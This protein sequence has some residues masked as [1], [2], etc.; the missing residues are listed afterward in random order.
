M[1]RWTPAYVGLGSNMG[2]PLKQVIAAFSTLAELP[3]SRL[4][5]RSP[6]YR[7][8][9]IGPGD[10]PWYVN[11]AAGLLTRRSPDQLL[12]DLLGLEREFGRQRDGRRWGPRTLDLDL[13]LYGRLIMEEPRLVIPHPQLTNRNFVVYPLLRIAPHLQLPDGRKLSAIRDQLGSDGLEEILPAEV[14]GDVLP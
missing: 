5:A 8:A 6:L 3:D 2:E 11:A 13:L 4:I 12:D 14:T 10:Q 9:P 7:S 1:Q